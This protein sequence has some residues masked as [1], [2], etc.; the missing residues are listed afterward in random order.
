MFI[1]SHSQCTLTHGSS[2]SLLLEAPSLKILFTVGVTVWQQAGVSPASDHVVWSSSHG[3]KL[4]TDTVLVPW[5][6]G[7][8]YHNSLPGKGSGFKAG[9]GTREGL[10]LQRRRDSGGAC[11]QS[12][13]WEVS[14]SGLFTADTG[15]LAK[16]MCVLVVY[17]P[18]PGYG[19]LNS[20]FGSRL[21]RF[22][23]GI[24]VCCVFSYRRLL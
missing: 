8:W 6:P 14:P 17:D 18:N 2:T 19:I 24:F 9:Y 4:S 7:G 15:A 5:E 16:G 12:W 22:G 1:K 10:I 21:L 23:L 20:G 13:S 3:Y 11:G